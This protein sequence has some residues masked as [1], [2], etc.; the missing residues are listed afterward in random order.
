MYYGIY[1]WWYRIVFGLSFVGNWWLQYIHIETHQTIWQNIVIIYIQNEL[2][3]SFILFFS[4]LSPKGSDCMHTFVPNKLN[5][6][7]HNISTHNID[8]DDYEDCDDIQRN[9]ANDNIK[10]ELDFMCCVFF[11]SCSLSLSFFTFSVL[12]RFVHLQKLYNIEG[13]HLQSVAK[14]YPIALNS[15]AACNFDYCIFFFFSLSCIQ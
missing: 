1:G 13:D 10:K 3:A 2:S 15:F 7:H 4:S 12:F 14:Q 9:N 11:R 5:A 6:F 8:D